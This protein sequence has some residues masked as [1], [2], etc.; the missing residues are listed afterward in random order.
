LADNADGNRVT[1]NTCYSNN[2]GI[3]VKNADSNSIFKNSALNNNY[4]LEI[5]TGSVGNVFYLNNFVSSTTANFNAGFG[6]VVGNFWNSQA[7][8]EYWFD[9]AFYTNYMGNYWGNYAGADADGDGIGD[10]PYP[11]FNA[12]ECDAYPLMTEYAPYFQLPVPS[13]S[14]SLDATANLVMSRVGIDLDRDSIDYGDVAPGGSSA[15]ETVLV[16][17]VGTVD[18]D[19]TLEV[20][21]ADEIAQGFYEQSLYVDAG[22]Y[23]ADAVIASIP[24]EG[25]EGVDTQLQVPL[26]W[27]EVGVQEAVFVFWAEAS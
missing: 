6:A 16:T 4:G 24:F 20:S 10:T 3:R 22:L 27:G 23:N 13:T 14:T 1:E 9:G 12:T 2:Y 25:S 21:G 17:N 5:A 26:S 7:Q 8:I 18:C 19:V 15:V 11:T